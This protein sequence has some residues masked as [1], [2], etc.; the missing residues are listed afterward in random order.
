MY[1]E[2]ENQ[3]FYFVDPHSKVQS[4]QLVIELTDLIE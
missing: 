1:V 3:S 4:N 2:T